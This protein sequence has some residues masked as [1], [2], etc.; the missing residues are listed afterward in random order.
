MTFQQFLDKY[1]GKAVDFDGYYGAQCMDL[2]HQYVYDVLELTDARI[3]AA[4]T[5]KDV[6]Q[7]NPFGLEYFQKINNTPTG[8]PQEGDIVFFG[9]GIGPAGHVC[10]FIEE[11]E[12][13][14]RSFDVNW[15]VG[16]PAHIQEHTYGYCLGWLRIKKD[17]TGHP[18]ASQDILQRADDFI[19][20][21]TELE[22]TATKDAVIGK[23]K[24][25]KEEIMHLEDANR[26]KEHA[27]SEAVQK[28][29]ELEQQLIELKKENTE[30]KKDNEARQLILEMNQSRYDMIFRE[31]QELKKTP[32]STFSGW[33]LIVKG[34]FQILK[35]R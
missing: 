27:V 10:I 34:F 35:W 16:S 24:G 13:R 11:D 32:T 28:A 15:P 29:G 33:Q 26:S 30:L 6:Y 22:T 5:A 3:L 18:T 19:A 17:A 2:M 20:V 12:K 14:F 9:T 21:C 1:N 7:G 8:V 23:I 4:P 31:V 25:L